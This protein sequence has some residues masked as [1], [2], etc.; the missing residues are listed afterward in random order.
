T[1]K[2]IGIS[3]V[4]A[5]PTIV[6]AISSIKSI[7]SS[8][9]NI[10]MRQPGDHLSR[11]VPKQPGGR[12]SALKK[13][14]IKQGDGYVTMRQDEEDECHQTRGEKSDS[15]KQIMPIRPLRQRAG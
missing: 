4:A 1:L 13:E 3:R 11:S 8:S 12:P 14:Y 2:G 6:S 7:G 9:P 10:D 5:A 15:D